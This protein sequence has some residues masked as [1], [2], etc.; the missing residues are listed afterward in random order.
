MLNIR[1]STEQTELQVKILSLLGWVDGEFDELE[2]AASRRLLEGTMT[3]DETRAELKEMRAEPPVKEDVLAA[4]ASAPVDVAR[5][6]ILSGLELAKA[7]GHLHEGELGILLELSSAAGFPASE[8]DRIRT[9]DSID[10]AFIDLDALLRSGA[11]ER[12]VV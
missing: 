8:L 11:G 9:F 12:T 5:A 2:G 10:Q 4:V 3:R 1:M 6:A 7:D